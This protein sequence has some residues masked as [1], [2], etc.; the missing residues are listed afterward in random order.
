MGKLGD[1]LETPRRVSREVRRGKERPGGVKK[2]PG[3][4]QE[5]QENP[6]AQERPGKIQEK[7]RKVIDLR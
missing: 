6:K 4:T 1:A 2:G 3:E 5:T 7:F